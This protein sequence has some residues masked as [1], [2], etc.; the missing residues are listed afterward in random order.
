[1]NLNRLHY[2]VMG[3]KCEN[4]WFHTIYL[5]SALPLSCRIKIKWKQKGLV[6]PSSPQHEKGEPEKR[7]SC[8]TK[9]VMEPIMEIIKGSKNR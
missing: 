9:Y 8:V 3:V 1:M 7:I 4:A 2:N 6:S 5:Y